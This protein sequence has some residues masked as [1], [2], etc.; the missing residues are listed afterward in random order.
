MNNQQTKECA[1]I[2]RDYAKA[3]LSRGDTSARMLNDGFEPEEADIWDEAF[4]TWE[5]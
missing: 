4:S 3:V 1:Q 5:L 2:A